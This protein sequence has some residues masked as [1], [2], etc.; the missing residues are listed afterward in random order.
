MQKI[1]VLSLLFLTVSL[2][3]SAQDYSNYSS[4]T[5]R[6]KALEKKYPTLVK[7]KSL[8]Q[9]LGNKDIWMLT[10]GTGNTSE[11]PAIAVVGGV[12]G[13]HLLGVELAI[14]FA[15]QLLA[16]SGTD[17]IKTLL[18][19][20]TFYVFPNMSPDA[21][22]Q[23]FTKLKYARSG[24]ARA[25]DDDRDGKTNED[26]FEDLNGDGKITMM[27]IEDPTGEWLISEEDARVMVKADFSKGQKGKYL[28]LSEGMDNDK[29][30]VF[31]EDGEGGVAFNKNMSYNYPNFVSGSG[32][33]MVSEKENRALLDF[34]FEAFNVYAVVSF[35]P[36]NN[37]SAPVSFNK[38]G[39]GK[40]IIS[41]W[42]KEDADVNELVSKS[43]NK[44]VKEKNAPATTG[45]PGNFAEWAY[46]HYGRFS[47]STPGWWVP[48]SKP[49]TTLKQKAL[50]EKNGEANYLRW[51]EQQKA[52]NFF[53]PWTVVKHPDFPEQKVE[54]GGVDPFAMINPPYTM[55]ASIV[56]E[57]TEFI[58]AL[59]K[60]A[61]E[62]ETANLKIEKLDGGLTRI[63][64]DVINKGAMATQTKVGEKTNWVKDIHVALKSNGQMITGKANQTISAI[65]GYGSE[66]LTWLVKASGKATLTLESPSN[67]K[68]IISINL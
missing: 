8:T 64:L 32:E 65:P 68:K 9:T 3:V 24:N 5:S 17:S 34:L 27:R 38:A 14:G 59:A 15:E 67:G 2:G 37:L 61:P 54:V 48:E 28:L 44:L 10:I 56:K 60:M 50:T 18:D 22:E 6:A 26:P 66:H 36:Y 46:F 16:Q 20:Q 21:S 23:Y 30:G 47:F 31:N 12:E 53:T 40:R 13:A 52:S 49:D 4:L 51:A 35:G 19:K 29:D 41:S 11:K 1:T 55:V 45:T 7:V 42:Y 39:V 33:H 57:H 58:E 63:S 25:T 43:Y 62:I